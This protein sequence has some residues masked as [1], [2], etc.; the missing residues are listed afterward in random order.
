MG[1]EE[2][3]DLVQKIQDS[4]VAKRKL[5]IEL[6]KLCVEYQKHMSPL[7]LTAVLAQCIGTVNV[8]LGDTYDVDAVTLANIDWGERNA[9]KIIEERRKPDAT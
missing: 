1:N 9:L 5:L 3:N 2:F 4:T 7:E 8:F 6:G